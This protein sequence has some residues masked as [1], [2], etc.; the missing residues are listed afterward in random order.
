MTTYK[1]LAG[2]YGYRDTP[3]EEI[4][5][6]F[7]QI[8]LDERD[9]NGSTPLHL[10]CRHADETAVHILLERGADVQAKDNA[11]NTPLWQL[12][13]CQAHAHDEGAIE[14]IAQALI[15]KGAKVPRS[16]KDTTALIRAIQNLHFGMARAIIDSGAKL[17]S[18]DRCERNALH[19]LCQV[20]GG[21]TRKR[22]G[23]E[24]RIADPEAQWFSDRQKEETL[25]ELERLKTDEEEAYDTAKRLLESGQ[26]DP[27]DKCQAGKTALDYAMECGARRIGALLTGHDPDDE[28]QALAGGMNIFQALYYKDM[29]A[30]DALL[31]MGTDLQTVCE[32]EGDLPH[33]YSG[34]S[35]L[36]CAL[37]AMNTEAV[38]MLLMGGA[39]PNF[40]FPDERT[41]FSTWVESSISSADDETKANPILNLMLQCGWDMEAPADREGNTPLAI[42][43]RHAEH[44]LGYAAAKFLLKNGANANAANN[45]GQTPAMNLYGAQFWDGH[46]PRFPQLP[47][48]YPYGNR[49]SQDAIADIFELLLEKGALTDATDKWGNTLLH[50]IASSAFGA[51]A[52]AAAELLSDYGM[53]DIEAVNDE[54]KTAMDIA[55]EY[56]NE[57]ILKYLLKNS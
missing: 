20:A 56:R 10:A 34:K 50:Y 12:A 45:Q 3:S 25:A 22:K 35:P 24:E 26:F 9:Y 46:I 7:R 19:V 47:R 37:A 8:D 15:G 18:T 40:V 2:L 43:C 27:E 54:G 21:I 1:E 49:I 30:V 42:A 39:D 14:K 17:D 44:E 51:Q 38:E 29:Q 6:S 55:T 31:R 16:G 4:H 13:N 52:K 32:R 11:G 28:L 23:D 48:S 36:A 53:P 57:A 41:A 5:E 33:S